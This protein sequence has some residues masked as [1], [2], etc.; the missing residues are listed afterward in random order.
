MQLGISQLQG[1]IQQLSAGSLAVITADSSSSA[2]ALALYAAGR[3]RG[4]RT[5]F[6][7]DS[8]PPADCIHVT[9]AL[10]G[11]SR[12]RLYIIKNLNRLFADLADDVEKSRDPGPNL[13]FSCFSR[14]GLSAASLQKN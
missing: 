10:E 2:A 11:L 9:D 1:Q 4:I 12:C 3:S 13:R 6:I 8:Q 7:A 5:M 14:A